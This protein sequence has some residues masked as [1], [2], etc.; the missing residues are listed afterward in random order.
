MPKR[1]PI[2]PTKSTTRRTLRDLSRA[3]RQA[4]E[5]THIVMNEVQQ[6]SDR[7]ACIIMSAMVERF[8]ERELLMRLM[9]SES[10]SKHQALFERDGALST[11]FGNIHLAYALDMISQ[12]MRD[13]LEADLKRVELF[14]IVV[15][16]WL[17]QAI[18]EAQH[19]D[20]NHSTA[21]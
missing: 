20:R 1:M 10:S 11:F 16:Q 12:D 14:Q 13:D 6:G 5:E 17:C 21:V 8:L 7:S 19:V 9:I 3:R 15:L 4:A 18:S 2:P